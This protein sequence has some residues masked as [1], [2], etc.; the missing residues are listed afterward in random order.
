M[1]SHEKHSRSGVRTVWTD[2]LISAICFF[3]GRFKS[4]R[5]LASVSR[6]SFLRPRLFRG[7][8]LTWMDFTWVSR[9]VFRLNTFGHAW[10]SNVESFW[11]LR[12]LRGA[13]NSHFLI[14]IVPLWFCVHAFSISFRWET[15]S[16]NN[17][18]CT[19]P[20]KKIW[21][22]CFPNVAIIQNWLWTLRNKVCICAWPAS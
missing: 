4:D 21:N 5:L 2:V 13:L 19:F 9:H 11:S 12:I 16:R 14:W 22:G 1:L 6:W 20:S 15:Y 3:L 17:Y 8:L 10:Q 7:S 18:S